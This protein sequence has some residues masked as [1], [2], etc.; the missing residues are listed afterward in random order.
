MHRCTA[1]TLSEMGGAGG[2]DGRGREASWFLC[3]GVTP[4]QMERRRD[5]GG[6]ITTFE[7]ASLSG[8]SSERT[9]GTCQV[10]VNL[11]RGVAGTY[12][13]ANSELHGLLAALGGIADDDHGA[14]TDHVFGDDDGNVRIASANRD[15]IAHGA[16]NEGQGA[17]QAKLAAS[18][19]SPEPL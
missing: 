9:Q 18:L 2:L 1:R 6:S 16:L 14:F 8:R 4:A 3:R 7:A 12:L 11:P 17:T 19:E 10:T 15:G 13:D 5:C